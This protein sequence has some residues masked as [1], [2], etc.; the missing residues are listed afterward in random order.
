MRYIL[1]RLLIFIP[2]FL[3]ITIIA[4]GLKQMAP[5]D[6]IERAV[7]GGYISDYVASENQYRLDYLETARQMGMDRPSFYFTIG[8]S[9][10]PESSYKAIFPVDYQSINDS[11]QTN[12]ATINFLIPQV[13]WN[14]FDNQYHQWLKGVLRFDFGLSFINSEPVSKKIGSAIRWTL[15]INGIA[16][17]LA[18][19]ISIGL[20]VWLAT[21]DR[22]WAKRF[23]TVGLYILY[24][25]PSFWTATMLVVFFTTPEYGAWT[26]IFPT[27]G[28]G[29]LPAEAPFWNRFWETAG[30]LILPIFCL[31]YGMMAFITMQMRKAM[32]NEMDKQYI[33]AARARGF[34]ERHVI[35]KEAFPNAL[36]PMIT[37]I[38]MLIPALFSGAVV[39]EAIFGIPGMGSLTLDAINNDDWPVVYGVLVVIAFI[40][41]IGNLV[42]D[43]LY[44][45]L[46][47]KVEF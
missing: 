2:T 44:A 13:I 47:P 3:A 23:G 41:M 38:A 30:H 16:I 4:F 22:S 9:A 20:G 27:N 18:F 15:T 8:S 17:L 19:G 45:W 5:G 7:K 40:T 14:G 10:Y 37:I 33:M 46:D 25:I 35:W 11:V 36:F 42:G 21:S 43:V 34:S 26:D 6:P 32:E 28:I 29:R 1:T 12:A 39:I 31:M 24:S